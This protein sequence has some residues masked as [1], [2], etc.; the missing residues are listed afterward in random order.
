MLFNLRRP[1]KK[2]KILKI[3]GAFAA[4][5]NPLNVPSFISGYMMNYTTDVPP[6]SIVPANPQ[7][8]DAKLLS[9]VSKFVQA[10]S[11]IN[12]Q[13]I[14]GFNC[15]VLDAVD[16]IVCKMCRLMFFLI[17]SPILLS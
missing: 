12:V 8:Q 1:T 10:P 16:T 4:P 2:K 15:V 9:A 14:N 5:F 17:L 11:N 7:W 3:P 13:V 6:G